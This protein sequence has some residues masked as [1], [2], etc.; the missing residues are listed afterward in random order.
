[1]GAA[2]LLA[3]S[4][5]EVEGAAE[6][7]DRLCDHFAEHGAVERDGACGRIDFGYGQARLS[8]LPAGLEAEVEAR[9][10]TYLAYVKMGVAEHVLEMARGPAP[11]IRWQGDGDGLVVPPFFR[12]MRVVSSHR[13]SPHMQRVRLSGEDLQRFAV[14]GLH[15]RLLF[16]PQGRA[17]VWPTL[18][19]DG[20]ILWPQGP[21]AL[22]N[23]VY[24]LRHVDP[25]AGHV[26]IDIV[27]HEGEATPGSRFALQAAPGDVVGMTG[28]GGG[29]VP[30]AQ[31]LLLVGDETAHPA[32][33][34]ILEALPATA[35]AHVVAEFDGPD[36][37]PRFACAGEMSVTLLP[38]NGL[39]AG[40]AGLLP[41][42]VE[43][44]DFAALGPSLFVWV[45]CEFSDFVAL[46]RHLRKD[47]RIAKK[48]HLAVAY[49]RRHHAGD[50]A[51]H[52]D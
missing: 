25:Q 49:W 31:T 41:R 3:R 1:M 20:R 18:A 12:E 37:A 13:L 6:L 32:I 48:D 4:T 11:V 46:R 52:E 40:T 17:P 15:V 35:R 33:A 36:D 29:D 42:A 14:G 47:R 43:A 26:D 30:E 28:P 45:G 23:R 22:D 34:R 27:L 44:L 24:T 7:L 9:D 16:P 38:R 10:P 39:P 21:D 51:R 19:E 8:A 5:I 50:D 2:M